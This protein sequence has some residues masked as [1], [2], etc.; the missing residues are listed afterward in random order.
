M[1]WLQAMLGSQWLARGET[2]PIRSQVLLLLDFEGERENLK[3]IQNTCSSFW[4]GVIDIADAADNT[5]FELDYFIKKLSVGIYQC[6]AL[7]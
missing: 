5:L 2:V 1:A 4:V 3:A 7:T 6:A